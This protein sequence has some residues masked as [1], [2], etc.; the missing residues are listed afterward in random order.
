[1]L[2][3]LNA[4]VL[5]KL[6]ASVEECISMYLRHPQFVIGRSYLDSKL[7]GSKW[8]GFGQKAN[9][10]FSHPIEGLSAQQSGSNDSHAKW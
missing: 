4:V 1:M 8:K 9:E 2:R 3:R 6:Q 7:F 5:C 10:F